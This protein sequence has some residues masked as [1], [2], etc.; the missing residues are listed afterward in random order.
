MATLHVEGETE[1]EGEGERGKER[2]SAH[3][4]GTWRLIHFGNLL[5]LLIA[6]LQ[7]TLRSIQMSKLSERHKLFSLI[8][9]KWCSIFFRMFQFTL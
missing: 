5:T 9:V 1:W 7:G 8:T 2:K 6:I 3:S 4:R